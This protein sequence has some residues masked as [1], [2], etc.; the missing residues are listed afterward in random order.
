VM[1]SPMAYT[2]ESAVMYFSKLP[3]ACLAVLRYSAVSVCADD[4]SE[5][6]M[7]SSVTSIIFISQI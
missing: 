5:V 4:V 6:T 7:S 3:R 2:V 1:A